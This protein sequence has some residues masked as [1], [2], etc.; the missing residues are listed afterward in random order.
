MEIISELG[1]VVKKLFWKITV[2]CSLRKSEIIT[3]ITIMKTLRGKIH[4]KFFYIR[5][6]LQRKKLSQDI[7]KNSEGSA[8][9]LFYQRLFLLDV[10]YRSK[11][12]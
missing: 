9:I 7:L 10:S 5:G 2:D 3:D 11:L 4:W 8:F 1:V 6:R 12:Y